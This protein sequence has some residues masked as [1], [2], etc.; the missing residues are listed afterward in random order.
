MVQVNHTIHEKSKTQGFDVKGGF[1]ARLIVQYLGNLT[2]GM[3]GLL[4]K[5]NMWFF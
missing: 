4:A 3:Y 5:I 2:L 1:Y